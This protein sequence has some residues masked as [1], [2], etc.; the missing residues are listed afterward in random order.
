MD[1]INIMEVHWDYLIVLDACRYD[2]FE[3]VW[4]KYLNGVLR[5]RISVGSSTCEWR[6]NSFKEHYEDTI[7]ISANPYINSI[8]PVKG[9]L[10]SEHF[11]KVYDLWLHNWNEDKGTV[12]PETVTDVATDIVKTHKDK[13][14][15]IHYLQ[16]HSPY[17]TLETE[18]FGFPVPD[19]Y[20]ENVL[21]GTK[22]SKSE[23]GGKVWLVKEM[24]AVL[25]KA[26]IL[27]PNAEWKLR[28]IMKMMPASPMDAARRKYG[29]EALRKAYKANLELALKEVAR[30]SRYLSGKVVISSDHGELLGEKR[31]YGHTVGS[32]CPYLIEVPW[33]IADEQNARS[34]KTDATAQKSSREAAG[35]NT[36]D[37]SHKEESKQLVEKRLKDLGYFD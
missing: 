29:D 14:A 12:L 19:P 20:N 16:P 7:Y 13:R 35:T 32:A 21:K 22:Q 5:K 4:E 28:E 37:D 8:M 34:E 3:Q 1:K 27:G 36:L 31:C 33:F 18:S 25:S 6:D 26:K 9:F 24:A 30:L 10:G 17:L 11:Y 23:S 2:Y 15:I